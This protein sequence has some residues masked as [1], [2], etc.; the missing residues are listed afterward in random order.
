[1]KLEEAE[2]L[3]KGDVV[4]STSRKEPRRNAEITKSLSN[5]EFD[6]LPP[7]KYKV[8]SDG[9]RDP[10]GIPLMSWCGYDCITKEN[11]DQFSLNPSNETK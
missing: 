9:Y 6:R 2:N 11:I 5:E 3:K 10:L 1:M 4:Y 7:M 8:T